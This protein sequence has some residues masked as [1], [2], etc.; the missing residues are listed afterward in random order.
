MVRVVVSFR[1]RSDILNIHRYLAEQSPGAADRMLFDFRNG[2]TS[3]RNS[4]FLDQIAVNSAPA[5]EG[6]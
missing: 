2:L 6:F 4:P 3:C 1:A 5:F